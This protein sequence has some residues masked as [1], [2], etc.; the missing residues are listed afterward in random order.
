MRVKSIEPSGSS[1][2]IADSQEASS[3]IP[4]AS[5]HGKSPFGGQ[6]KQKDPNHTHT[7]QQQQKINVKERI[8]NFF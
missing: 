4:G 3:P 7:Q 1:Q 5:I 8:T 6:Y 2:A